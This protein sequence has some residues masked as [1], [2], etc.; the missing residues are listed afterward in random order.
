M[1]FEGDNYVLL[2]QA[3]RQLLKEFTAYKTSGRI[4]KRLMYLPPLDDH[5]SRASTSAAT[6]TSTPASTSTTTNSAESKA[7]PAKRTGGGCPFGYGRSSAADAV[8]GTRSPSDDEPVLV[9][10][11]M[12]HAS[13]APR[14]PAEVL[15]SRVQLLAYQLRERHALLSLYHAYTARVKAGESARAAWLAVGNLAVEVGRA[16]AE[17]W[18]FEAFLRD[19]MSCPDPTL[20]PHLD[21]LR[22]L[23]A[24]CG[25][26]GLGAKLVFIWC[27]S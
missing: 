14:T 19:N 25:G 11:S 15:S 12:G 16:N 13:I 10:D 26:C 4:S 23:Y 22:T 9:I 17:R 5:V 20:R 7:A 27:C 21:N 1:T 8:S 24:V 3:A 2:Q 6:P 18:V